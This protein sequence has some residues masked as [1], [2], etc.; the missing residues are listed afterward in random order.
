LLLTEL[1]F[2]RNVV[3]GLRHRV[4]LTI[5]LSPSGAKNASFRSG[6]AAA[7]RC[8]EFNKVVDA[9]L[10][11]IG[12]HGIDLPRAI[13]L[14]RASRFE[15]PELGSTSATPAISQLNPHDTTL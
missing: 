8:V 6:V 3:F 1:T 2:F 11:K 5:H 9:A 14:S 7:D 13:L 10:A 4:R 12:V 15:I